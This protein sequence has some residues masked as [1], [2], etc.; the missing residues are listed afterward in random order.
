LIQ[1]PIDI[2]ES[3]DFDLDA[4]YKTT[5]SGALSATQSSLIYS[6]EI[7]LDGIKGIENK[8]KFRGGQLII[9]TRLFLVRNHLISVQIMTLPDNDENDA[10][11]KFLDS[12]RLNHN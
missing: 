1:Y 10:M 5:T 2:T 4:F 6:K 11:M 9:T 8:Q 7:E 12:L 3:E